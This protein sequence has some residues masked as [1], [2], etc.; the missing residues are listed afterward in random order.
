[1]LK[2]VICDMAGTTINDRDEVYRVLREATERAGARYSDA[3]FQEYMGTEK[4]WAII[5]LLEIGGVEST[6][7]PPEPL[8]GVVD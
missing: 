4:R 8:P 6:E 2:L 7:N 5:K 1:M 3:Q